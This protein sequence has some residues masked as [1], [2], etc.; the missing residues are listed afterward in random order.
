MASGKSR[1]A[2]SCSAAAASRRTR[3]G[4]PATWA[5]PGTTPRSAA[6][7]TTPGTGS[8]WRSRSG[9]C[10]STPIDAGAPPHG[11]RKLTD[12]TNRL[13][14][15]FGVL[16]N[17]RGRRFFDEGE[18][19][20]FYTYAK[21]GGIILNQPGGIAFQIFDAKVADLLEARYKTGS[22][23]VADSIEELVEKLPVDRPTGLQALAEYNA[24]VDAGTFDPTVKDGVGTKGLDPPKSNWAQRLDTPPFVAYPVTGGITF[25]FGGVRINDRAQVLSTSWAP[26]PG[27]YACGE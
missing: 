6:P 20:Q 2:P 16:V 26:I 1:R 18:D 27:L 14:Y 10:H 13:S 25:T 5:G 11:D 3:N 4:A 17:T 22:P 21:L 19:F 12:K 24:A 23:I 7:A 9:R 8:A 15:P